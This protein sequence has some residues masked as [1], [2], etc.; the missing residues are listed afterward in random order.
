MEITV[1][2]NGVF[3]NISEL[4]EEEISERTI[5][6]KKQNITS[7]TSCSIFSQN[8]H[9]Q[10]TSHVLVDVGHGVVQSIE[11]GFS[12]LGFGSSSISDPHLPNTLL[13]THSHD[14][15]IADLPALIEKITKSSKN[16]QIFCTAECYGQI[17]QKFP[18]LSSIISSNSSSVINNNA[19]SVN[20][21]HPNNIFNVDNL[22]ITPIL[23]NHGSNTPTGS[24]I[25]VVDTDNIKMVFGWDFLSLVNVDE[26]ILWNPDLLGT[27]CS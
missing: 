9:N 4:G 19:V 10:N 17:I 23:A 7:N 13:I 15:H 21:I 3:P 16:L 8:E 2:I 11:R 20:V 12:K 6:V 26:K 27:G 14:D 18:Q 24:V 25:Y 5:E 22:S 1:R